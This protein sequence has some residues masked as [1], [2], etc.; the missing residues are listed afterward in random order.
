VHGFNLSEG[1]LDR[2]ELELMPIPTIYDLPQTYTDGRLAPVLAICDRW[3]SAIKSGQPMTPSLYEGA[4]SQ[5]L[6]D[7]AQKSHDQKKWMN[8]PI[9]I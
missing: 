3:V 5:M 6:M 9:S 4:W 8:V 1:K 2:P 7:L